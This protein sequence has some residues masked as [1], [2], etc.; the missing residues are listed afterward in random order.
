[1]AVRS[2]A[3]LFRIVAAL[4]LLLF[5]LLGR[6]FIDANSQTS[7]EAIHLVSGYSYLK[8]GSFRLN[9]E[10]PPLIKELGA[11]AVALRYRLPLDL[12]PRLLV[13]RSIG[14]A[15]LRFLYESDVSADEILATARLPNLLLGALLVAAVYV[16]SRRLWGPGAACLGMA[17]AAFDPNL[18]AHSSLLT[19]DLGN[20]LF[21]FLALYLVW[22][23]AQEPSLARLGGMG[24]AMGLALV[25]KLSAIALPA[26]LGV[27]VLGWVLAGGSFPPLARAAGSRLGRRLG[28]AAL[29]LLIACAVAAL[30]IPPAYFFGDMSYWWKGVRAVLLHSE[31]GHRAFFL[32]EYGSGGWPSY[33]LVAFLIKTP[34]GSMLLILAGLI[35]VRAGRPLAL[36]DALFVVLPALLL[37]GLAS[38]SRINIGLRHVLPIY[39]LLFVAASRAATFR[40]RRAWLAP[41]L[42]TLA[43]AWTAIASLWIAP[44]QLA[45]FNELVGG[46]RNGHLYLNDSNIDWGQDLKGLARY[47]ESRGSGEIYLAYS[48]NAPPGAYGIRY[49]PLPSWGAVV[50]PPDDVVPRNAPRHLLAISTFT[51]MGVKLP[52]PDAYK[53]LFR[54]EPLVR[55]GY[56]IWVYDITTDADAHVR[57]AALYLKVGQAERADFELVK[58]LDID[59]QNAEAK[60][61]YMRRR[62]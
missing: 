39:P 22:E 38:L 51:L 24:V 36:R 20:A 8:T 50:A 23:H 27:V 28:E 4:L 1:M 44:H 52:E 16:W 25:T 35:F 59:P 13:P 18:L 43:L 34:V 56:S 40:F 57:L 7:D 62:S 26:I 45:Y 9:V 14:E 21:T 49:Q 48:G 6:A 54:R 47:L 37:F 60:Q 42:L 19:T 11:L 17:L 58:A 2:R 53:W 12:P 55:I 29:S 3:P 5:V 15:G 33:F 41:A 10:H 46:P 32:G 61:L 31:M 30:M